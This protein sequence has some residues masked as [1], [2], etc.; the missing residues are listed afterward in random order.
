MS[1]RDA[2]AGKTISRSK[3]KVS[4]QSK[5]QAEK[6]VVCKPRLTPCPVLL[7]CSVS[8][9]TRWRWSWRRCR[10]KR[11]EN[12]ESRWQRWRTASRHGRKW[13][14]RDSSVAWLLFIS[15][16][17][18]FLLVRYDSWR[19]NANVVTLMCC[20]RG[21]QRAVPEGHPSQARVWTPGSK[22]APGGNNTHTH[23]ALHSGSLEALLNVG[24]CCRTSSL[25]CLTPWK[26]N[27][28]RK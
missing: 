4:H 9:W 24:L 17:S 2:G 28:W 14:V 1:G 12:T 8:G 21:A 26:Q 5:S 27:C 19:Q 7:G 11:P 6:S 10:Q 18:V 25:C 20:C 15:T 23:Y 22:T 3:R 13:P 16:L